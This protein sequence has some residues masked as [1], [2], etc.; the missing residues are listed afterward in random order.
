MR[1]NTDCTT[2]FKNSLVHPFKPLT[3]HTNLEVPTASSWQH[4][5]CYLFSLLENL[6]DIEQ[7]PKYHP[8]GNALY[9]SLQVFQCALQDT[10]N[11]ILWAAA[12]LHDVGK[13]IDYPDHARIGAAELEGLIHPYACWLIEHHLDL[14]TSPRRTRNKW[15]SSQKLGDLG[16]LRKWDLKGR[17]TDVEVMSVEQALET[18]RSHHEIIS[19]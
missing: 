4:L 5:H 12:L 1:K 17:E 3:P 7:S 8:E 2:A 15:R 10:D 16:R 18:L 9:H 13:A 14:L 11:P 19:I 6:A